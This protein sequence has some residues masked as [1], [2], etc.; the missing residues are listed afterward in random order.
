MMHWLSVAGMIGLVAGILA[1]SV[2][3][4]FP[5]HCR[6]LRGWGSGLFVGSAALLGLAFPML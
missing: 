3:E 6:A 1:A 4:A 5:A 2:A